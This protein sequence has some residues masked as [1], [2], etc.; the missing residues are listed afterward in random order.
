[1]RW[2]LAIVVIAALLGLALGVGITWAELGAYTQPPPGIGLDGGATVAASGE[3]NPLP[4]AVLVNGDTFNF[5]IMEQDTSRSYEFEIRNEG[6][7]PLTLIKR[8]TTCK[9][10]MSELS[11]GHLEPGEST[12]VK[13]DWMAYSDEGSFRHGALI[14]TNDP[15]RQ[16]I[17]FTIEGQV[18]HSHRVAPRELVFSSI[19]VSE[20]AS[21][22]VNLYA[23]HADELRIKKHE[24]GDP[25]TADRFELRIENMPAEQLEKIEGAKAGK[26]ARLIVKP[27]LP[28][29]E[30]H[31]RI[32]I[33]LDLPGDP[34]VE[35]PIEGRVI[36]DISMVGPRAWDDERG[37]LSLGEVDASTGV[38]SKG[39]FLLVKGRHRDEVRLRA[40]EIR[41]DFLRI[42]FDDPQPLDNQSVIKIPFTIEVPPGS[43][44][45]DYNGLVNKAGRI[46]I[47][48]GHPI[49][50]RLRLNV[51]FSVNP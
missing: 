43:P 41:P 51:T 35:V 3:N 22:P 11:K 26:I 44:P 36:G 20:E 18:T 39:M 6:E 30:I 32:R 8:S 1:M 14:E 31:Q 17:N 29:G 47:E 21:A 48:T 40:T 33:H 25:S 49:S 10:T 23:F 45:G 34:V 27:G 13:L 37:V 42:H 38:K 4:K 12:K 15:R 9:C 46:E 2:T 24:F 19:S 28:L 5:G 7:A 16:F 50:P